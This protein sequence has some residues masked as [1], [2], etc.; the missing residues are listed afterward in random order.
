[1]NS[2]GNPPSCWEFSSRDQ[3]KVV[4]GTLG[5]VVDA[6]AGGIPAGGQYQEPE[7]DGP[8]IWVLNVIHSGA[9]EHMSA[10]GGGVGFNSLRVDP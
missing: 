2:R 6:R 9:R 1:M 7:R 4:S 10:G 8:L 3:T 5:S